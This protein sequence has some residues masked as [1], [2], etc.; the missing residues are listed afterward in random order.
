VQ[1]PENR[2]RPGGRQIAL[3][4]V[5]IPATQA[6]PAR[7]AIT[8]F[9]G[10]P[11]QPATVFA[12]YMIDKLASLRG[13]RDLLFIDQRG[14]GRSG[15][16]QCYLRDPGNPQSYIDDFMPPAR[17]AAC[18]DSLTRV[19][20]VTRYGFPELAHDTDAVRRTLGYE[21]LDL[22]GGSYGT[23]AAQVYLRMYPNRVGSMVLEGV[24]PPSFLQPRDYA[25]DTDAAMAGVLGDCRADPAC[26][27]AFSNVHEELRAVSARLDSARGEA[28]ILDPET[29]RR[30]R[31]SISRGDFAETL[32]RML[33]NVNSANLVPFT[34]HRAYQGDFR[35]IIRQT[36]MDRRG[37]A[38]SMFHGLY[39][40]LTCSEDVPPIDQAAAALDNGRTLLGDYRVRQ[41]ANACVG[42]PT[43]TPPP[44]YY[45]PV[46]SGVPVLLIS[47]QWDPVTPAR[48]GEEVVRT[49][50]NGLHVVVPH[51]AHSYQGLRGTACVDSLMLRFLRER[52]VRGLDTGC[53]QSIRR[54][55]FTTSVPEAV[56]VDQ[57]V[58]ERLAGTYES[59]QPRYTVRFEVLEG[60]LRARTP[61]LNVIASP[62]SPTRF[63]WEGIL[64]YELEFSPDAET[65]ILRT[66]NERIVL[67]RRR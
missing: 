41:Q 37:S 48:G 30:M 12:G 29:G 38:N 33:Y 16:L 43:Y 66:P 19:A 18:R 32:R 67:T 10:G 9:G 47:G 52:S 62:L 24:T 56:P 60:A 34:I 59:A 35:P 45:E 1:V 26:A 50:P 64:G 46:R 63:F 58:L 13:T 44:G 2:E 36:L 65:V 8:F 11:G 17:A 31:L 55:P 61:N 4:V 28:E 40:A 54:P 7:E 39:L 51:G 49:F 15:P 53:V 21:R 3:N 23:R 14:T 6:A 5:V 22:W 20:D 57:A 25:R 27:A 42:W